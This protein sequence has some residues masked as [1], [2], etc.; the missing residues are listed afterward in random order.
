[1]PRSRRLCGIILHCRTL[2]SG[3][4][5]GATRGAPAQNVADYDDDMV[6]AMELTDNVVFAEPH[7]DD[8]VEVLQ[9][10]V[11]SDSELPPTR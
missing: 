9:G 7:H 11:I 5:R 2:F 1:M 3:S 10:E 6:M 4:N 8:A